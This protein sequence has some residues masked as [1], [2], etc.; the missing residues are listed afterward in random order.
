MGF[1]YSEQKKTKKQNNT[2]IPDNMKKRFEAFSAVSFDDVRIHYNSR[3]PAKLNALAYTQGTQV[4]I[5]PGQDRCLP[6]E[7]GHVVQQKQGRVK[8]T[9]KINGLP[10]NEDTVLEKEADNFLSAGYSH[11]KMTA[12][13]SEQVNAPVQMEKGEADSVFDFEKLKAFIKKLLNK[14]THQIERWVGIKLN[15]EEIDTYTERVQTL[16][17]DIRQVDLQFLAV[18]TASFQEEGLLE[19]KETFNNVLTDRERQKFGEKADLQNMYKSITLQ[20][21]W[22]MKKI[23]ERLETECNTAHRQYLNAVANHGRARK[24]K[25]VRS[26]KKVMDRLKKKDEEMNVKRKY[27]AD[28]KAQIQALETILK[29]GE[30]KGYVFNLNSLLMETD[31]KIKFYMAIVAPSKT[32][33][34]KDISVDDEG[35]LTSYSEQMQL[36]IGTPVRSFS[37]YLKYLMDPSAAAN[38]TPLIR[39]IDMRAFYLQGWHQNAVSEAFKNNDNH[40]PMNEDHKVPNQFGTP[41]LSRDFQ[42]LLMRNLGLT[43]IGEEES[44]PEKLKAGSGSFEEFDQFKMDIGFGRVRDG[45]R[46]STDVHFF[47]FEHTAFHSIDNKGKPG[48]Y[49]PEKAKDM[50][51]EYSKLMDS[52]IAITGR[53]EYMKGPG[54]ALMIRQT[55]S[56]DKIMQKITKMLEANHCLP[57][58][59]KYDLH[60]NMQEAL[61]AEKKFA[62]D[63]IDRSSIEENG[64][65][66]LNLTKDRYEKWNES[67]IKKK[68]KDAVK[69]KRYLV[70]MNSGILYELQKIEEINGKNIFTRLPEEKNRIGD[71]FK[72]LEEVF[73][74]GQGGKLH[75]TALC[76]KILRLIKDDNVDKG[77]HKE[78]AEQYNDLEQSLFAARSSGD[79][80]DVLNRHEGKNITIGEDTVSIPFDKMTSTGRFKPMDDKPKYKSIPFIGGVSGTT[81][82]ISKDLLSKGMLKDEDEYWK[83]QMLN[84]SFMIL[85]SYH[86]FIEVIYRAATTRI[87]YYGEEEI[88]RCII[89][90]LKDLNA[91]SYMPDSENILADINYIILK[92]REKD[93]SGYRSSRPNDKRRGRKQSRQNKRN[94]ILGEIKDGI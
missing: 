42:L 93:I 73:K 55:L 83:F 63:Y 77:E 62:A 75:V 72:E 70:I 20:K 88:S 48:L 29:N 9:G 30:S 14:N 35:R 25:T 52:L 7:L 12:I 40:N 2:G 90:Y 5:A 28:I 49:S 27:L 32:D 60:G 34:F 81:R 21:L 24:P 76:F 84:A 79:Y 23:Q 19:G 92:K 66:L 46:T 33:R 86:S 67:I 11:N 87:E 45:V 59:R 74:T 47:D 78:Q 38:N 58:N 16:L 22:Y 8:P 36:G 51:D 53:D 39:S 4:Y 64:R 94:R 85:Y 31:D 15:E 91:I 10:V 37:W 3:E 17:E 43:T 6:H 13:G 65:V 80:F 50:L 68:A 82:D 1:E 56:E 54:Q 71:F 69:K 18:T 89:K 61:E 26:L 41:V 44:M 57:P